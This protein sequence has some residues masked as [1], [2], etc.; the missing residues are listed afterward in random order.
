MPPLNVLEARVYAKHLQCYSTTTSTPK[1]TSTNTKAQAGT[2][3]EA[4]AEREGRGPASWGR[5]DG[6]SYDGIAV[7]SG[8]P[9]LAKD[10]G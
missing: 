8:V 5:H 2:N 3:P 6:G 1:S 7:A 4:K 9:A 10:L